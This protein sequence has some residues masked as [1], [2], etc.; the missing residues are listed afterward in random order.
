M[1]LEQSRRYMLDLTEVKLLL[2]NDSPIVGSE[3]QKA[4]L[5]ELKAAWMVGEEKWS[6]IWKENK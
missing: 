3:E 2:W 5:R 6:E 1:G 4:Q